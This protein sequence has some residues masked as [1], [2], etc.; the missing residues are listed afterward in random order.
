MRLTDIELPEFEYFPGV[1][2]EINLEKFN[3]GEDRRKCRQKLDWSHVEDNKVI[4]F[5]KYYDGD[6]SQNLIKRRDI[7][8]NYLDS[9]NYFFLNYS[10]NDKLK[11][12]EIHRGILIIIE[13]IELFFGEE[14]ELFV[15]KLDSLEKCKIVEKGNYLYENLKLVIR[16]SESMGGDTSSFD[17]F[18]GA[19]NLNHL[20][21]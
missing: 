14:I 13:E 2:F 19:E 18:Y 17:Y 4:D 5:S 11:E 15:K 9:D 8:K 12:V 6:T 3:W 10:E 21:E 20:K 7:Y 16:D 1:G